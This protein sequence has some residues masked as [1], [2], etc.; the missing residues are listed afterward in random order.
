MKLSAEFSELLSQQKSLE[1][2]RTTVLIHLETLKNQEIQEQALLI[3]QMIL[4]SQL[5]IAQ[6]LLRES[7]KLTCEN[8]E[9]P[10]DIRA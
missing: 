4:A 7:A 5:E 6:K 10:V 1:A 2:K 3:L 9:W 8:V